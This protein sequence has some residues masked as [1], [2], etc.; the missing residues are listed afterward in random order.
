MVLQ[1]FVL[2]TKTNVGNREETCF[3]EKWAFIMSPDTINHFLS[4]LTAWLQ[5]NPRC[6]HLKVI[7]L[8]MEN[9]DEMFL[10]SPSIEQDEDGIVFQA[11]N[12][13]TFF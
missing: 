9:F 6:L 4:F 8:A 5:V 13:L 1:V 10:F 3:E 2:E 7:S 12:V 11:C